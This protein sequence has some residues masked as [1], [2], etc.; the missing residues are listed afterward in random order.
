[1]SFAHKLHGL[2]IVSAKWFCKSSPALL[3]ALAQEAVTSA[4]PARAFNLL[5]AANG[6]K[7]R[8]TAQRDA[9]QTLAGHFPQAQVQ[10]SQY[11]MT[12]KIL[13]SIQIRY[14]KMG[15][16]GRKYIAPTLTDS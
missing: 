3:A 13:L 9:K 12:A 8:D 4:S 10:P 15:N 2:L 6:E 14:K 7:A 5:N 16:T 11:E 1:M